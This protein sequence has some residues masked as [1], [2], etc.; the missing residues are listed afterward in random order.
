MIAPRIGIPNGAT[1][2]LQT[3]KAM[4]LITRPGYRFLKI[5]G[6]QH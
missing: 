5:G 6:L 3:R 2:T 4:S 1:F